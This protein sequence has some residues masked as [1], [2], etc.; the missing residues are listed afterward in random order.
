MP[1]ITD[2]ELAAAVSAGEI[3]ALT[4][5]TS[6]FDRY[7]CNLTFKA[8][9]SLDQ[10]RGTESGVVFSE[11]VAGGVQ[12]HIARDAAAATSKLRAALNQHRKAWRQPQSIDILGTVVGLGGDPTLLGQAMWSEFVTSIGAQII[13]AEG[14]VSIGD[15]LARYFASKPPFSVKA[16]K[17]QEFPDAL[18]LLS[19]E[20]WAV[21]RETI[22]LAVSAD[23]DWKAYAATSARLVCIDDITSAL[24][25]FNCEARFV[26]TRIVAMLQ[27]ERAVEL[28]QEIESAIE[29][30][31]DDSSIEIEAYADFEFEAELS[32]ASLQHWEVTNEVRVVAADTEKIAFAIMLDCKVLFEADIGWFAYDSVDKD[33]NQLHSS[34]ELKE[35]DLSIQ[36]TVTCLREIEN[37]PEVLDVEVT[38]RYIRPDLGYIDPKWGD[39]E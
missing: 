22:I 28:K 8:F 21:A 17:K 16:A 9:R 32:G 15:V 33:W 3:G 10:F 30:F 35:N 13:P 4:I 18:A 5:D 27:E 14:F 7:G 29:L 26:A 37:E 38:K 31:L 20:A 39:D 19:L 23:N 36:L 1:A 24:D 12:R 34:T 11:V 25:H 6:V 2:A